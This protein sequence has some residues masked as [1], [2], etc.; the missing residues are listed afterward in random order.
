MGIDINTGPVHAVADDLAALAGQASNRV[1]QHWDTT[2]TAAKLHPGWLVAR[3]AFGC[4]KA[5]ETHLGDLIKKL[6]TIAQE[7]RASADAIQETD[8]ALRFGERLQH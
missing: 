3:A 1:A 7:I 6:D 5:W 2:T 4:E 8:A